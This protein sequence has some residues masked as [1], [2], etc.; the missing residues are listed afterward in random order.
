M[1]DS[2]SNGVNRVNRVELT[3]R[4]S[5][6]LDLVEGTDAYVSCGLLIDEGAPQEVVVHVYFVGPL[7]REVVRT[8]YRGARL[9]VV[10]QLT[11]APSS[12]G[13]RVWGHECTVLPA[14]GV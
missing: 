8:A 11:P 13:T 5:S 7:A 4:V 1:T 9:R 3:G 10:G 2:E 14:P 6:F 12:E